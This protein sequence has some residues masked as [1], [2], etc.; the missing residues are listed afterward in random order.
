MDLL[1]AVMFEGNNGDAGKPDAR[2][3]SLNGAC[4]MVRRSRMR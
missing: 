3:R 4:G 1:V 2:V